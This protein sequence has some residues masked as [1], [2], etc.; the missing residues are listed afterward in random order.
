MN[1]GKKI[2]IVDDEKDIRELISYN[3]KK[4]NF[5]IESAMNGLEAL[6]KLDSSFDLVILDVM[7]P[8]LDGLETCKKIRASQERFHNIPIILLTAKD[9]EVNEIVGLEMGADDYIAKPVSMSK[10][11]A[12]VR[13][14]L[15]RGHPSNDKKLLNSFQFGELEIDM[16]AHIVKCCGKKII[17]TKTEFELLYIL[18]SQPN[19]VYRRDELLNRLVGSDVVVTD[20]VIDVH[21]RK[22]R[23]KLDSCGHYIHTIRGVGYAAREE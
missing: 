18:V 17:L 11:V 9:G 8:E 2:L 6:N 3:L 7:M 12:R 23:E 1:N 14:A 5:L 22:I 10:L 4:E 13:A 21:I 16:D 20:R 19:K 15:R